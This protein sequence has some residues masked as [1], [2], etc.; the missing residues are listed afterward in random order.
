MK[1]TIRLFRALPIKEEIVKTQTTELLNKTIRRGFIFSPEVIANYSNYDDLIKLIEKEVGLT[2]EQLNS[3][4]HKSWEKIKT[5]SIEQLVIEQL[6]HYFTTYGFESLGIYDK[7]SVYI[8]NEELNIPQL[9]EGITLVI[10]K[11]YTKEELKEKLI[12]LLQSGIALSEDTIKDVMDVAVFTEFNEQDVSTVRNKE[13]KAQLYEYLD[14]VPSNPTEFLRY[15]IYKT[16]NKTLLIKNEGTIDEI[17]KE[18]TNK[19]AIVKLFKKYGEDYG[20]ERL[21]EVFL[22]FKPLFLAFKANSRLKPVVNKIRRLAIKNHKPMPEDY[23]NTITSKIKNGTIDK[24]KLKLELEKVNI[25]RKIR[26]L[27]SIQYRLNFNKM[28]N[29]I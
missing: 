22:R 9:E 1:S 5:A 20:L 14:L 21:A 12:S 4:F 15:V 8:P 11:G 7:D 13:V 18:I 25:F 26:V 27:Y 6:V 3:S 2:P 28:E 16:I 10:I 23:L 24:D 29:K 19:F 17:K